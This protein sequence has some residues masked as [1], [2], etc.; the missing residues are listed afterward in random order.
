M[1]DEAHKKYTGVSN[2]LILGNLKKLSLVHPNIIIRIPIIPGINDDY[3][4]LFQTGKFVASLGIKEVDL[5]PYHNIGIAKYQRMGK[6]YLLDNLS[7]P[8]DR[9]IQNIQALMAN[10]GLSVKKGG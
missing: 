4:N 3:H 5:L 1:D 8:D 6:K 7:T 2:K 10:F 9:N